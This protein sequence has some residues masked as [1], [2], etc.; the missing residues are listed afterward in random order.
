MVYILIRVALVDDYECSST[1]TVLRDLGL[2]AAFLVNAL[3]G[4]PHGRGDDGA[5]G[6]WRREAGDID[7]GA[8]RIAHLTRRVGTRVRCRR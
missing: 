4:A 3:H 5:E 8:F 1:V 6:A 7:G 2:F